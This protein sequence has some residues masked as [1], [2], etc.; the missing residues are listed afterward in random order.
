MPGASRWAA[1]RSCGGTRRRRRRLGSRVTAWALGLGPSAFGRRH[2]AVGRLSEPGL[3]IPR[4][5]CSAFGV[6]RSAL[7]GSKRERRALLVRLAG[8]QDRR[9]ELRLVGR[10]G[11]VLRLEAEARSLAVDLAALAADGA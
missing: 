3:A 8:T 6:R 11:E 10:V 2:S 1:G 4:S 5:R 9:R 7:L